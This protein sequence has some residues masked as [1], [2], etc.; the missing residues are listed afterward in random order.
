MS[1][2]YKFK[3][4]DVG[5]GV[6]EAEIV[7]WHVEVGDVVEEDQDLLDVMTDKATVEMPSPVAG[8][9]RAVFGSEGDLAPVGSVLVEIETEG[10]LAQ[11]EPSEANTSETEPSAPETDPPVI[12]EKATDCK[13]PTDLPSAAADDSR[14]ARGAGPDALAAPHTR[15]RAFELGIPLQFVPGTGPGGRI[16]ASD[17][18]A[19]ISA[20]Q[21]QTAASTRPGRAKNSAINTQKIIGVRRKIAERMQDAKRRI[22]HF[23]YVEEFDLTALEAL[24]KDL[25]GNAS[26][27]QQK[28]TL[29]PFFVMA[30][31]G[32]QRQ[33]PKIN[34]LY[35]DEENLLHSYEG[36]HVGIAT[37]TNA[38]LMVP[39]V[40]H[41]EALDLWECAAEIKRVTTA[42]REGRSKPEDL[43]GSTITVT[44]LGKMGGIAATPVIN[45]PEVAI[46]GPN[47]IV[48]RPVVVGDRIEIRSVMNVSSSFDHRIV[49]GYDAAEFIQSLK[50]LIEQP[51]RLFLEAST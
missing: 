17:L 43:S 7:A 37:Q 34:S 8:T 11:T 18:D 3:L 44:S 6:A 28:L 51:A 21:R 24:R 41:A 26:E 39:V 14:P 23:S 12:G 9:I 25:N 2:V 32:L 4:P 48:E 38:G 13:V 15:A 31:V 27:G 46:I 47:R 35:L 49:D 1:T 20:N 42:A 29:L 45:A 33:F 50:R 30:I 36:V 22:P 19:Y 10:D 16:T 5:E 40:R